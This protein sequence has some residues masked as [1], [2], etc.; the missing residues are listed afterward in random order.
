M[1][2]MNLMESFKENG[3]TACKAGKAL[4]LG[5]LIAAQAACGTLYPGQ[6]EVFGVTIGDSFFPLASHSLT[7]AECDAG[8]GWVPCTYHPAKVA[9]AFLTKKFGYDGSNPEAL[10]KRV[11]K[12]I[13][14]LPR[15]KQAEASNYR[16]KNLEEARTGGKD[17]R[18]VQERL[19]LANLLTLQGVQILSSPNGTVPLTNTSVH[20][21]I[22]GEIREE[23]IKDGA[24]RG[25]R[26]SSEDKVEPVAVATHQGWRLHVLT[27]ETDT[28][29]T[30]RQPSVLPYD[31][32]L[33]S[34]VPGSGPSYGYPG[35]YGNPGYDY[36]PG[37]RPPP[38][39]V[40]PYSDPRSQGRWPQPRY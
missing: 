3:K 19:D 24:K 2:K 30:D 6:T 34:I 11:D 7:M 18:D 25:V 5:S 31:T 10:N 16:L 13:A 29:Q 36:A 17:A 12:Q 32:S 28:S 22:L 23:A 37:S 20:A 26:I 27:K 8:E 9:Y 21:S 14:K 15:G 39:R 40:P 33:R 4:V 1:S 38:Y 35:S